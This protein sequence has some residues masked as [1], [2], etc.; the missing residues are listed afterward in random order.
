[1]NKKK[2]KHN[3]LKRL[4]RA[5]KHNIRN[6][7]AVFVGGEQ[8]QVADKR[9]GQVRAFYKD[10]LDS[11]GRLPHK[12]SVYIAIIGQDQMGDRYIKGE[13]LDINQPMLQGDIAEIVS[14]YHYKLLDTFNK[15]HLKNVGWIASPRLDDIEPEQAF[16]IFE[17]AGAFNHTVEL[18]QL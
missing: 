8:I 1:M 5:A 9:K 7:Y 14:E 12:W 4:Q 11:M 10:E 2:R 13:Q 3:P 18:E 6:L 15:L 16:T 17:N